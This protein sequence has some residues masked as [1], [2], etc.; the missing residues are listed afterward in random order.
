MKQLIFVLMFGLLS[1]VVISGANSGK[2]TYLSFASPV[3]SSV[4][5]GSA[6]FSI[7]GGFSL[8]DCDLTYAAIAKEDTHLISLLLMAMSQGQK[9]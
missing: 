5:P 1:E 8:G 3:A 9:I 2:I 7:E 4:R 6:Q